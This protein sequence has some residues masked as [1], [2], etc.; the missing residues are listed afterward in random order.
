MKLTNLT[1][2]RQKNDKSVAAF[3]QRF[4]ETKNRCYS[5]VLSD[6][7]MVE[8]AF[9]GLLPHLREKYASQDFESISQIVQRMSGEVRSYE[10]RKSNYTKK[11]NYVNASDSS[12]SEDDEYAIGLAEWVKTKKPVSCPYGKREPEK[13]GFDITKADKI[14]DLL[15]AEGQLR[16]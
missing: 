15:L 4:R 12:D 7:Q 6:H 13:F 16:L 3:I 2:L 5:L 14:F 9:Q 11:V 8:V 1:S 10:P